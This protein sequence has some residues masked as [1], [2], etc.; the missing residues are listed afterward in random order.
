[1]YMNCLKEKLKK[2][3]WLKTIVRTIKYIGH[4]EI[5]YIKRLLNCKYMTTKKVITNQKIKVGFVVQIAWSWDK[6]QPI[7]E[8]MNSYDKEFETYLFVIPE[9]DFKTYEINPNYSNNYFIKK[10]P[11]SI[12][13]LDE[14]NNCLDIVQ[15]KLDYLFY[16]RPY[17]YRIPKMI[18]SS[19]MVKYV[20][21]CYIPYGFTASDAFNYN[22]LKNEFFD[23]QQI[24]FLDSFYMQQ[25]F[26]KRYA[27]SYRTGMKKIEY[28]GYPA[29]EKY[30]YMGEHEKSAGYITWTP[31]WSFDKKQGGST[32]F[33]YK[34][35][36]LQYVRKNKGKYIFRPHPLIH[37]E[38]IAQKLMTEE[39]W[40]NYLNEL[41][42]YNVVIDI[43]SPIDDILRKTEVLITDFST[44][45]G[46]FLMMNRPIIYCDNGIT[47][48]PVYEEI[49]QNLYVANTW[50]DVEQFC[51]EILEGRDAM[52]E[53]RINYIN[54]YKPM[55]G[56]SER[57]IQY[58]QEDAKT[59]GWKSE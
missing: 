43:E 24:L 15:F 8:L 28:L 10:Y 18:R 53:K 19:R 9:E 26:I 20:K 51:K 39:D 29:L 37:A 49:K 42:R 55:I 3:K 59:R 58:I 52:R 14:S 46:N 40:S 34:D 41:V 30:I 1:M 25:L 13:V 11:K 5:R 31:R 35:K 45:I 50:E 48:N 22:N 33:L 44:I 38:L 7:Y 56:A 23:N 17:D 32:F 27:F 16:Q 4:V 6:L 12:K 57:I 36:F 2:I 21:C 47:F 54:N